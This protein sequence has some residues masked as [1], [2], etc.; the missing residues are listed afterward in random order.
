[1]K[2]LLKEMKINELEETMKLVKRVFDEFEAPYYTCL[3]YTSKK[4][5]PIS[6]HPLVFKK[7]SV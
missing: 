6:G 7:S 2:S 3:L 1:M 4:R 5:G